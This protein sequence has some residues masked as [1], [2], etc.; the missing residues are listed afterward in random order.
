MHGDQLSSY[1]RSAFSHE[2][3]CRQAAFHSPSPRPAE[4]DGV[5]IC[6][7]AS[8]KDVAFYAFQEI[9]CAIGGR[10]FAMHRLGLGTV[11]HVRIGQPEECSCECMGFLSKGHCKHLLGL[12][13]PWSA[14]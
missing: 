9:P 7:L 2:E 10:A 6:C 13:A 11:Y 1:Q 5:G 12:M 8:G 3:I 4:G 14:V